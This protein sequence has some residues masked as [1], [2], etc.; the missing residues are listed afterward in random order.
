MT[1][2]CKGFILHNHSKFI[3]IFLAILMLALVNDAQ[4]C[5]PGYFNNSG[6]CDVCQQNCV[7]CTS[8]TVCT[9][10]TTG[11]TGSICQNCTNGYY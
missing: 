6:T 11:Y 10:C 8:I 1:I 7:A 4:A 5:A 2:G 3:L 9:V